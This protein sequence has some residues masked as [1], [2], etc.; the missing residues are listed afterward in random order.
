MWGATQQVSSPPPCS[1]G[2]EDMETKVPAKS[3]G[4]EAEGPRKVI[5]DRGKEPRGWLGKQVASVP[6]AFPCLPDGPG[7]LKRPDALSR[8]R[9]VCDCD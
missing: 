9:S 3:Q 6:P 4:H 1:Q 7:S 5:G 8:P 2:V